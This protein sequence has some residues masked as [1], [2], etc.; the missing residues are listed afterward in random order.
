[1]KISKELVYT[2]W[3]GAI[4]VTVFLALIALIFSACARQEP[5]TA[6]TPAQTQQETPAAN[7]DADAPQ[8]EQEPQPEATPEPV[9]LGET[10]DAGREYLDRVIFLGDS[11][12]YGI[13]YYYTIGY[14]ELCP[15]E[16]IW[17]PKSGT[18]TL[19]YQ[20]IATVVYPETDE[21]LSIPE[22][23]ARAKPDILIITLGV[24][25][26]SFMDED[27][28][29]REYSALVQS[30][31]E[32]SPETKIILNSIY[33]VAASYRYQDDINNDKI[34]TANGWVER[35]AAETGC[36]FLYS[37]E[38]LIGDDGYL[39]ESSQNGDGIHLTG[40][41]FTEVMHYI[42]THALPD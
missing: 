10:A 17:T 42:R 13:G 8:P 35:V 40:E 36:R 27:F 1:M 5:E 21:E 24:N 16:Q 22:A 33:P 31:Q 39:P 38:C 11:T 3:S 37:F 29:V 30:I 4:I 32:A 18:L 19:S 15:P 2:L 7:G 6:Q 12:T 9:R 23:A 26:V 34:R 25:G 20:S 41:A 14:Q 28:F